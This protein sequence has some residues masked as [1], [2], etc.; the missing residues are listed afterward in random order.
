MRLSVLISSAVLLVASA[1]TDQ[2][3]NFVDPSG[4]EVF[5][6]RCKQDSS[7]CF[8]KAQEA[9][10]GGTYRVTDSYSNDGGLVADYIPGPVKWYTM[11]LQCGKPDGVMP[12]FPFRGADGTEL[13]SSA[14][15]AAAEQN[16]PRPVSGQ[17]TRCTS[18]MIGNTLTTNCY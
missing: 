9:C 10:G 14:M 13:F 2:T 7:A 16:A 8:Q 11:T 1:C 18:T 15:T 5:T 6:V 4:N 17:Q 12:T 3:R